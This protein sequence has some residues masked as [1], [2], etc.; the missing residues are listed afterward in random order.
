MSRLCEH[1]KQ[2][3]LR[4]CWFSPFFFRPMPVLKLVAYMQNWSLGQNLWDRDEIWRCE[5]ETR[6]RLL[7]KSQDET[8]TSTCRDRDRDET[9]EFW[10]QTF[11]KYPSCML[12]RKHLSINWVIKVIYALYVHLYTNDVV[13]SQ[14]N[15]IAN[16]KIPL[17]YFGETI[18]GRVSS[19]WTHQQGLSCHHQKSKPHICNNIKT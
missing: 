3:Y 12:W 19:F 6:P 11:A 4:T 18:P 1:Q 13:I 17:P 16:N 9:R 7:T 5:T 15:S 8:E 2:Y 14:S 10:N